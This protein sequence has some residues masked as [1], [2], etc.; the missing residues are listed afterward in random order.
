MAMSG[1]QRQ[2]QW[3]GN[4]WFDEAVCDEMRYGMVIGG[5]RFCRDWLGI[6]WCGAARSEARHGRLGPVLV[7]PGDVWRNKARSEV[8]QGM[9]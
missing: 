9:A 8:I 1:E 5:A 2:G 4:A 3:S 7:G 6:V